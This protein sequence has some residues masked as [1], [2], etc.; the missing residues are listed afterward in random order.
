[1]GGCGDEDTGRIGLFEREGGGRE[2][3][4]GVFEGD[5]GAGVCG[6]CWKEGEGVVGDGEECIGRGAGG[7][8]G[9]LRWMVND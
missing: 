8:W 1:M 3:E 5:D 6:G 9:K 7:G 4:G 2:E